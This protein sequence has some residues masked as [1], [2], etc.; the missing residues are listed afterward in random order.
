MKKLLLLLF[1]VLN[2]SCVMHTPATNTRLEAGYTEDKGVF[3]SAKLFDSN[4]V[5]NSFRELY[6]WFSEDE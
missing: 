3:I 4:I 6:S 2:T 1:V 5:M